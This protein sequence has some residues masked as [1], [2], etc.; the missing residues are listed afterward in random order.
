MAGKGDS[1][2]KI[3]YILTSILIAIGLPQTI[4]AQATPAAKANMAVQITEAR[5]AN[6]ALLRQ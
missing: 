1:N 3:L 2:M 4:L 6:A 5:K